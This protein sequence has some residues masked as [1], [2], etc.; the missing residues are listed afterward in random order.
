M[1]GRRVVTITRSG[2]G[3]WTAEVGLRKRA[4]FLAPGMKEPGMELKSTRL[5]FVLMTNKEPLKGN[6]LCKVLSNSV[7][8]PLSP[9]VVVAAYAVTG[10]GAGKRS[11]LSSTARAPQG[12]VSVISWCLHYLGR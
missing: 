11:V 5:V 3:V 7:Q 9:R 12:E 1:C 10:W 8:C 2:L 4:E 6:H